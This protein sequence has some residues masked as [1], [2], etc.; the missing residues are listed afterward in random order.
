VQEGFIGRKRVVNRCRIRVLRG[1]PV[2][3]GDDLGVR[4]P[5]D[6]RG[7]VGGQEGVPQHVHAAVEVHDDMARFDPID[8]D[9]GGWDAPECRFGHGHIG[10]QR[11]CR[12]QLPQQAT[13]LVHVA[14]RG[15]R[16]LPQ[17][18]VEAFSLFD[19]HRRPPVAAA[20]PTGLMG[21]PAGRSRG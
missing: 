2:V 18:R 21:A 19:A 3:D 13:L 17:D 9:L 16:S 20:P 7:Q 15:E 11:L 4:A 8:R 1:E 10:G 14:V 5:T 6:L 12:Y